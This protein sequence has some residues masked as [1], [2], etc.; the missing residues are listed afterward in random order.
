MQA[1]QCAAEPPLLQGIPERILMADQHVIPAAQRTMATERGPIG[2][3]LAATELDTRLI[4]MI[5]ALGIIWVG[6][7]FISGG[8]F[9]TPRNLW[10]L[11]V[12]TSE[13]AVMAT[14]MVLIIVTRNI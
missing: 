13:V 7:H 6:F 8:V 2:R 1:K 5:A 12:Q 4:G 10:N 14:G 3:F 11:S 9:L